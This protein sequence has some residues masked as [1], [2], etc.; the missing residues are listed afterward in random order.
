MT[1]DEATALASTIGHAF[2]RWAVWHLNGWWYAA[3]SY[4]NS[5]CSRTL[6]A[7]GPGDLCR[8]LDHCERLPLAMQ[9]AP[10]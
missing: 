9:K 7:D 3:G 8:Q 4:P 5:M 2:P 6:H 10:L 1:A